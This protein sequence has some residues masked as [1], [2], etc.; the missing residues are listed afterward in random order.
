MLIA[1]LAMLT[2]DDDSDSVDVPDQVPARK[3]PVQEPE[4]AEDEAEEDDEDDGEADEYR[5]E[6]IKGHDFTNDGTTIYHIKWLG[7]E[8]KDDLTWEPIEN[9]YAPFD[10]ITSRS[11]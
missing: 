9:L 7:Y 5:V 3:Q 2:D 10:S 11:T 8:S 4:E 6:A 1:N